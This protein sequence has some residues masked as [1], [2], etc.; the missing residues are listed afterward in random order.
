MKSRFRK[1]WVWMQMYDFVWSVPVTFFMFW[2]VGY[3][4]NNIFGLA[5]GTYDLAFIQP[6]FLAVSVSIGIIAAAM[7]GLRFNF[8][9]FYDWIYTKDSYGAHHQFSRL[10]AW[11]Q[12]VI[13]FIVFFSFVALIAKIYLTLV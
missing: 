8:K 9:G 7:F 3:L 2:F 6:L 1:L 4:L 12:F 10:L 5:I 11:Q 13:V